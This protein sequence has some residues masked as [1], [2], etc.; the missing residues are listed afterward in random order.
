MIIK[1]FCSH[2][3][4]TVYGEYIKKCR[5]CDCMWKVREDILAPVV[6]IGYG[7]IEPTSLEYSNRTK[8]LLGIDISEK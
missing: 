6:Q 4:W 3:N 8:E 2:S 1:I 5:T 7:E